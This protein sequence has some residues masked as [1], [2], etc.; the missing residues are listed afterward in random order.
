MGS[1]TVSLRRLGLIDPFQKGLYHY[2]LRTGDNPDAAAWYIFN[3]AVRKGLVEDARD[4]PYS[5][6]WMFDWKKAVAPPEEFVPPD[7]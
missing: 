1:S 6:S 2:I 7:L 4:W 3:H 5:G